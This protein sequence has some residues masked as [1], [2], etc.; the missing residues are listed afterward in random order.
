MFIKKLK[1]VTFFV[2]INF[3]LLFSQDNKVY[4]FEQ[5][6]P[7][8][9]QINDKTYVIN[10]WATWCNPCVKEMPAFKELHEKYKNQNVEIL[11]VSLD[12]GRDIQNKIKQF[13][14]RHG[15]ELQVVILD[16]PDS[17]SWIDKVSP[18]WSGAIPATLI[19]NRNTRTFYERSFSFSELENELLKFL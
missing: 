8:L 12:F 18:E 19:Y 9:H 5:F 4:N 14:D 16:D 3:S 6:E 7:L 15:I 17:N 13:S 2:I 1:L 11:L 10:F